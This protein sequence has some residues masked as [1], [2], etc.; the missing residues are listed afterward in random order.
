MYSIN[1][2]TTSSRLGLCSATVWSLVNQ[3]MTPKS[4][5]IW[6]SKEAYLADFG[7]TDIPKWVTHLNSIKKIVN[8]HFT[9]NTGPYRKII[10]ALR[11]ADK[12]DILVYADD[13]VFYGENWLMDLVNAFNKHD[14][15]CVVASRVRVKKRNIF[16]KLRSYLSFDMCSSSCLLSDNFIITGVGGCILARCHIDDEYIFNDDFSTVAPKTDDIWISKII[17]L[18]GSSVFCVP[19]IL[20]HVN[21]IQHSVNALSHENTYVKFRENI[22]YRVV[23]KVAHSFKSYFGFKITNNDIAIARVDEYFSQRK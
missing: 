22:F 23:G 17:E 3:S 14:G 19:S 4:I 16:G 9:E 15:N 13:D 6:V 10:P 21:E 1:I 7:V 12:D 8:F 5:D 20:N 11:Y 18:S 2:T